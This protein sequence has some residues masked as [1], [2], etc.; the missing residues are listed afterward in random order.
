MHLTL[1]VPELIWPEPQDQ[2]TLAE[3]PTPGFSWLHA[4][5]PLQRGPKQAYELALLRCFGLEEPSCGPLR[6]LGEAQP[7]PSE[8]ARDGHWLC[9]DPVHLRFHHER[10]ILADAGAFELSDDEAAAL[11]AALNAEFADIGQFHAATA[12]R[13]YIKLNLAVDHLAAPISAVAGKRIP[14]EPIGQKQPLTRLLNEIQ[15]FLHNH[16]VN[17]QRERAGHPAVNS[18]WFWGG[19]SLPSVQGQDFSAVWS[20][21]PL[22][23]GLARAAHIASQP[24]PASLTQLLAQT[25][26]G[27]RQLVTLDTLLGPVLYENPNDWRAAWQTLEKDWFAPLATTLGREVQS[28]HL[29]APT[30]YGCLEWQSQG[31]GRWQFWKKGQ[32]L[33]EIAGGLAKAG[34]AS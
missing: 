22:A 28:L 25:Q 1:L 12:R 13:W 32:T 30:I 23:L 11:V 3:L 19:G 20:S 15:M 21:D 27:S 18:V 31:Q 10:V 9:A 6:L 24:S 33:A 16:P 4:R 14:G 8:A 26:R 2:H 17:Q 29:I 5:A 34:Q 7:K